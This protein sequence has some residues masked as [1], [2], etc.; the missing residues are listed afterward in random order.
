ME[1]LPHRLDQEADGVAGA[2]REDMDDLLTCVRMDLPDDLRRSLVSTNQI[3]NLIGRVR[4]LC[5]NVRRWRDARMV[6]RWTAAEWPM[7]QRIAPSV[8]RPVS[9]RDRQAGLRPEK[10]W[11]ALDAR[12]LARIYQI[13]TIGPA[14]IAKHFLPLVACDRKS[15]FAALSARVGSIADNQLDGWHAHR[16]SKAALNMLIRNFAI[17]LQRRNQ[18]SLLRRPAP[19]YRGHRPV[20]AFPG[21]CA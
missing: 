9:R 5:K 10:T 6:K 18:K 13:N 11:R 17:E 19:G 8:R 2:I 4:Q 12:N 7:G 3:E 20:T 16:A 15:V 21:Q 14:L 1:N